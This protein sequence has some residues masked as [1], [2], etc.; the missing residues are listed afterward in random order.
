LPAEDTWQREGITAAGATI[1]IGGIIA[2]TRGVI[3]ATP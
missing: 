2:V 1:R 3:T